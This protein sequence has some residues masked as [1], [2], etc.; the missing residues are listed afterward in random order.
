MFPGQLGHP[1]VALDMPF[2]DLDDVNSG[3]L[4]AFSDPSVA[5]ALVGGIDLGEYHVGGSCGII[6]F[7]AFTPFTRIG[8]VVVLSLLSVSFEWVGVSVM[9][10][11]HIS[12][13]VV[14]LAEHLEDVLDQRRCAGLQ[15][16]R[17]VNHSKIRLVPTFPLS[18]WGF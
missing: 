16:R 9:L 17:G 13:I 2:L 7:F 8:E 10:A 5:P 14:K 3:D 6:F 4:P 18:E 12:L 11:S 15:Y 1:K